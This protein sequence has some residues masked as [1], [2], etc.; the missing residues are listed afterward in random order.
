MEMRSL[1]INLGVELLPEIWTVFLSKQADFWANP[2]E[3]RK[4][5]YRCFFQTSAL[6]TTGLRIFFHLSNDESKNFDCLSNIDKPIYFWGAKGQITV[7]QMRSLG[8]VRIM[9]IEEKNNFIKT[10]TDRLNGKCD[11]DKL[12][13][14]PTSDERDEA[15]KLIQTGNFYCFTPNDYYYHIYERG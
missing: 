2:F 13:I 3:N 5:R 6:E 8:N 14:S 7:R 4:L 9:T 12:P 1:P 11:L 15:L 10:I